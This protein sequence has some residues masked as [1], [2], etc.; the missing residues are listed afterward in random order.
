VSVT[1]CTGVAVYQP[2]TTQ[3]DARHT[4]RTA[5][6]ITKSIATRNSEALRSSCT[7]C[8]PQVANLTGDPPAET[9]SL[10]RDSGQFES[11]AVCHCE[12]CHKL[13]AGA[14]L[15]ERMQYVALRSS[16]AGPGADSLTRRMLRE[17]STPRRHRLMQPTRPRHGVVRVTAHR[18]GRTSSS[19]ASPSTLASYLPP[20]RHSIHAQMIRPV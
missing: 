9:A 11:E 8:F 19:S 7:F 12:R 13:A 17:I 14:A 4:R 15:E 3:S 5:D 2:F 20:R 18:P 6:L 16:P 1:H 10:K